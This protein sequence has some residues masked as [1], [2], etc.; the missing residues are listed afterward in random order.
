MAGKNEDEIKKD[1]A[2]KI[3]IEK[4]KE[5][6]EKSEDYKHEN[7]N[8]TQNIFSILKVD[9]L[10]IRHSNFLS[11]LFDSKLNGKISTR[12]TI[13]FLKVLNKEN[14]LRL[15]SDFSNADNFD[16]KVEREFSLNK[17]EEDD[18]L[19][20]R[21]ID[22]VLTFEK[23][24][25]I[26]VIENKI[27]STESEKQLTDY[28]NGISNLYKNKGYK[29]NF[30]YLTLDGETPKLE[31]DRKHWVS[32]SYKMVLKALNKIKAKG[33]RKDI[34]DILV[35]HYIEILKDKTTKSMNRKKEFWKLYQSSS[36]EVREVMHEM[37]DMLPRYDE[38]LIKLR[39]S[40]KQIT[41][42]HVSI[43]EKVTHSYPEIKVPKMAEL[44]ISKGF[45][46]DFI[47]F[48][49]SNSAGSANFF[50]QVVI[51]DGK[52]H[53]KGLWSVFNKE[54]KGKEIEY[55]PSKIGTKVL[56]SHTFKVNEEND[57]IK[58]QEEICKKFVD[59]FNGV[60][61]EGKIDKIFELVK[62]YQVK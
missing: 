31:E 3:L 8:L 22:I 53:T 11:W 24:K 10:E 47:T 50:L 15:N 19:H 41:K 29:L 56:V 43:P 14:L 58:K 12:F 48:S 21:S 5:I 30:I 1:E 55:T 51:L 33:K 25:Q 35:E 28:Y 61:P 38:R 45:C 9:D 60:E 57:E 42:Y 46:E 7:L 6:N 52:E 23:L 2:C 54:F 44:L 59:F 18:F 34:A 16:C 36:K 17:T 26:I 37:A 40:C 27:H 49:V 4:I 62:N 13:E 20:S 32:A 39:E